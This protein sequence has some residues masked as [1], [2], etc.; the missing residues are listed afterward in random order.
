MQS[1]TWHG[2]W[3]SKSN[4]QKRTN[5]RVANLNFKTQENHWKWN[6][7]LH[8]SVVTCERGSYSLAVCTNMQHTHRTIE[9]CILI[10]NSN[11][12]FRSA[13]ATVWLM[14]WLVARN[15][16]CPCVLIIYCNWLIHFNV[17]RLALIFLH[18][19]Q[20]TGPSEEAEPSAS[21]CLTAASTVITGAMV[22]RS[23]RIYF[24]GVVD[25]VS[26][27]HYTGPL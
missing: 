20:Y 11:W 22:G 25:V 23:A 16:S 6:K 18:A 27:G 4:R 13:A 24:I 17:V 15:G 5:L 12:A 26:S 9:F 21:V 10:S 19:R 3:A 8:S 7:I 1:K 14:D 2:K